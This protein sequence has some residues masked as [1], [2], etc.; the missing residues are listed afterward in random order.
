MK[1]KTTLWIV[2]LGLNAAALDYQHQ[3][4]IVLNPEEG[5]ILVTDQITIPEAAPIPK[6]MFLNERLTLLDASVPFSLSDGIRKTDFH[7]INAGDDQANAPDNVHGYTL[8]IA[9][10]TRKFQFTYE[11]VIHYE[12]SNPQEEYARGFRDTMASLSSEGVYLSGASYWYPHFENELILMSVKIHCPKNWHVIS[13][14]Y[15]SSGD[16]LAEWTCSIAMDEIY[17]VGG[18]LTLFSRETGSVS[19]QV[20]LHE[21]DRVLANK[22]LETTARYIEMYRSLIGPYP[23]KKFALV[24]N[25]W[26]TGY[27]MPSFTLLGPKVIRMPFILHSS[28]PHEILHNWWGNSVFVDYEQGNWCEGITAYEADHL[29]KEQR[30]QGVAYRRNTLQKYRNYVSAG[31]DFPIK[32]FRSRHSAATEAVGYGKTLMVFHMLRKKVGDSNFNKALARFYRD[33]RGQRAS[34]DDIRIAFETTTGKELDHFFKQWIE[35]KGAPEIVLKRVDVRPGKTGFV[36]SGTI[37]QVQKEDVFI[38]EIPVLIQMKHETQTRTLVLNTRDT[39]FNLSL[40]AEPLKILLDPQFDT[41]RLLD[42]REIPSSVGNL[43]GSPRILAVLPSKA[44]SLKL[45]KYRELLSN[46]SHQS[47]QIDMV[48]DTELKSIPKNTN[49]WVLGL[50]NMF[51]SSVTGKMIDQGFSLTD[52]QFSWSGKT[53]DRRN[54]SL[55]LTSPTADFEHALGLIQVAPTEAFAGLGRKLPHYGKYSFL[56][57]KGSE[58]TNVFKGQGKTRLSPMEIT[59]VKGEAGELVIP[60]EPA[61]AQLPAVFSEKKLMEHINFLASEQLQGRGIGSEGLES[62]KNYIEK[63]FRDAGLLPGNFGSFEQTFTMKI[64]NDREVETTNLIGIIPGKQT[65]ESV[66]ITAHYDHLGLGWPDVHRGDKGKIH[67]GADDNASGTA[68]LLEYVKAF[69]TTFSKEN[70]PNK[71][72]VFIAFSGEEEGLKGSRYFVKN[73][74]LPLKGIVGVINIDTVGR[75]NNRKLSILG[76]GNTKEWQHIFM[77]CGFVTGLPNQCISGL[78]ESSDQMSFVEAGIPAVQIFSGTHEDYHRPGDTA[79]K[80]DARGM[81]KIAT[82]VKEAVLYL[83]DR[84]EPLTFIAGTPVSGP[85]ALQSS[86]SS[87]QKTTRRVSFGSIPDMAFS[88]PGVRIAGTVPESPAAKAGLLEGDILIKLNGKNIADLRGFSNILK[89]LSPG[90]HVVATYLRSNKEMQTHVTVIAR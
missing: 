35:R 87:P 57:F 73:P 36:I 3:I 15:G 43:F 27:G 48:M 75:L 77:G 4:D 53:F 84:K 49:V 55:V 20:Y 82:F 40:P 37:S 31:N 33:N 86:T 9:P 62:A 11:G 7:S 42:P 50:E 26:E 81:V 66:L 24:E 67:F 63:H 80:I 68:L 39:E 8:D 85:Q 13:Q 51:A 71:N 64:E 58:P 59:L 25:F 12:L 60:P 89:T 32:E 54:H 6:Q 29:I 83:L 28:Y 46:W 2:W 52:T 45:E 65:S 74:T 44:D 17:L 5:K 56:T 78:T 34:F 88:G 61:L 76:T 19:T 41:F 23:F 22:Y 21:N 16:S 69:S 70:K 47:H 1:M 90:Q 18:P 14:G 10:G 79:D 72:L 30:G 38:M